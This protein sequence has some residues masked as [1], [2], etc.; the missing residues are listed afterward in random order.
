MN[1]RAAI[2]VSLLAFGS[3]AFA[4]DDKVHILS[5]KFG[6]PKAMKMCEPKL[7]TCEGASQCAVEVNDALC[8]VPE[9][10]KA[11]ILLVSFQCGQ[12]PK[13]NVAAYKGQTMTLIK[14]S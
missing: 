5:A 7:D 10:A 2:A 9:G 4:A 3:H 12:G 8:K 6:D 14:C 11:K 13:S 1:I